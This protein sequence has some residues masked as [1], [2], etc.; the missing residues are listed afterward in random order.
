M[1]ILFRVWFGDTLNKTTFGSMQI[2]H[3]YIYTPQA[4]NFST[5]DIFFLFFISSLTSRSFFTLSVDKCTFQSRLVRLS[6][7][8]EE[9][10]DDI[11]ESFLQQNI[12]VDQF[13]TK[14]VRMQDDDNDNDNYV[15]GFDVVI[16]CDLPFKEGYLYATH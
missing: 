3:T 9:E 5:I 10:S 2:L 14:Y 13:I 6:V 12:D 11:A 7:A 8:S 16:S 15:Y 1:S 4:C